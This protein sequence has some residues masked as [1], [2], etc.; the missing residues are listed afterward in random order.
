ML[1]KSHC[2]TWFN[3]SMLYIHSVTCQLKGTTGSHT[4]EKWQCFQGHNSILT[5]LETMLCGNL[6]DRTVYFC[7]SKPIN[8]STRIMILAIY[9][10]ALSTSRALSI[11]ICTYC[12]ECRSY[13]QPDYFF[14]KTRFVSVMSASVALPP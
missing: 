11:D 2:E 9:N 14:T 6:F 3:V 7:F 10:D 8:H 12:P 13:C 1:P 5:G 4:F